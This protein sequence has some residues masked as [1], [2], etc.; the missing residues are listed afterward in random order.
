[1]MLYLELDLG[2]LEGGETAE[3]VLVTLHL[4]L[5]R[6]L[7]RLRGRLHHEANA[8]FVEEGIKVLALLCGVSK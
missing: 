3:G 5:Q 1:M 8:K 2:V 7:E 4:N 6:R